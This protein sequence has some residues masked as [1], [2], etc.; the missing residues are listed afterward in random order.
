MA[1]LKQENTAGIP[2]NAIHTTQAQ[3]TINP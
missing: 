3:A 1:G 2:V